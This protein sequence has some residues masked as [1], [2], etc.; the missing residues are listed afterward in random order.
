MAHSSFIFVL[1]LS[2]FFGLVYTQKPNVTVALDGTGNFRSGFRTNESAALRTTIENTIVIKNNFHSNANSLYI[3]CR[4][5]D[6]DIGEH[7]LAVG[8]TIAWSF[9]VNAWS[10]T[11]FHCYAQWGN[12]KKHFNA[13][14][15]EGTT[16]N[17][18]VDKG[19]VTWVLEENGLR[20][21]ETD[22]ERIPQDKELTKLN[23]D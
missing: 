16:K 19:R 23:W 6:D 3:H 9:H 5:K 14:E 1:M 17:C 7:W 18:C 22:Q 10:T 20:A 2:L 8:Q 12:K 11:L 4:S 13:F 15:W 21:I